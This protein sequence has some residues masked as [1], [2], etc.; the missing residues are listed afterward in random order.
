MAGFT[1]WQTLAAVTKNYV[2]NVFLF[3]KGSGAD[4]SIYALE[5]G[6]QTMASSIPVVI[7]SDQSAI[8]VTGS[9][10][11]TNPSVGVNGAATPASSTLIGGTDGTDLRPLSVSSAGILA[12]PTG[13]STAAKQD[14][15]NTSLASIDTKLTSQATAAKQDT[16]NTSLATIAANIPAQGQAAMAASTPVVI[17]SNQ[18]AI[19]VTATTSSA[20]AAFQAEANVAFGAITASYVTLFTPSAATKILQMRNNMN[21]AVSVSFDAGTTTHYVLDAGDQV[22]LDLLSN[23]LVMSTMAIQVKYTVGQP[24]SGSFRINGAH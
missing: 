13:A 21:A 18:S 1:S 9:V 5:V 3:V 11:V 20:T 4:T 14:T 12:L 22:S 7:A 17:A 15:G 8:P 10:T 19:P 2:Q 24:G 16:G 6:Q 23:N